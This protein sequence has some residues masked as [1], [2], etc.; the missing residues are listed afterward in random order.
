MRCRPTCW[1][2]IK[3]PL[4]LT[5]PV[6]LAPGLTPRSINDHNHVHQVKFEQDISQDRVSTLHMTSFLKASHVSLRLSLAN[7]DNELEAKSVEGSNSFAILVDFYD[8][9]LNIQLNAPLIHIL[10]TVAHFRAVLIALLPSHE[11]GVQES[12]IASDQEFSEM[13]R[14]DDQPKL[15]LASTKSGRH[16]SPTLTAQCAL[17]VN[18]NCSSTTQDT[19]LNRFSSSIL[20]SQLLIY[21]EHPQ[22]FVSISHLCDSIDRLISNWQ[23]S[24]LTVDVMFNVSAQEAFVILPE[25]LILESQ[26]VESQIIKECSRVSLDYHTTLPKVSSNGIILSAKAEKFCVYRTIDDIQKN[27]DNGFP[28]SLLA[29]ERRTLFTTASVESK[30]SESSM[31]LT[32]RFPVGKNKGSAGS[33]KL[34]S[35]VVLRDVIFVVDE[36]IE[37]LFEIL[38]NLQA[39]LEWRKEIRERVLFYL[40]KVEEET[41]YSLPFLKRVIPW[42]GSF[43]SVSHNFYS[44]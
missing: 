3:I 25:R 35:S 27:Y 21:L 16:N 10:F 12:F 6:L 4:F 2:A 14:N 5:I 20:I 29:Q 23:C 30:E 37:I 38:T 13:L 22:S 33:D 43:S 7:T 15:I 34:S 28:V 44:N 9:E 32:I 31:H 1:I 8:I 18:P 36:T 40:Q 17:S 42:I 41:L 39:N 24:N 19:I 26:V 11:M